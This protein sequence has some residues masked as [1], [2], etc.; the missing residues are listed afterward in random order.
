MQ[1]VSHF[2][3]IRY[4]DSIAYGEMFMQNE[5]EMG[6]YNLDIADVE[7]QRKRF[8]LYNAVCA[9]ACTYRISVGQGTAKKHPQL[10]A[11]APDQPVLASSPRRKQSGCWSSGCPSRR[12]TT[13]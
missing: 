11:S 5:F 4:T 3:D 10:L 7:T 2:K 9:V 13:C 8:D 1:G 6:R 12:T